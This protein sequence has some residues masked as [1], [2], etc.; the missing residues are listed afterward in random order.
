MV[1][2]LNVQQ[3]FIDS[4]AIVMGVLN[5]TPDSFYDGG[6]YT[7]EKQWMQRAETILEEG[8]QI[9]DLGAVSTR[10]GARVPEISDEKQRLIPALKQIRKEFPTAIL[11]VDTFRSEIAKM[12]VDE[13]ADMINDVSAGNMDNKMLKTISQLDVTYILMHMQGVPSNMQQ[14][15][16]YQNVI[17]DII[18]FFRD[19]IKEL[20][21]MGFDDIILDPGLGFGKTISHNYR[22]IKNL[23]AFAVMG[24]PVLVGLSR[25]SMITK[26]LNL[27]SE[28]ALNGTTVMNTI[29]LMNGARILRVHD[30]KEAV[31]AAALYKLTI[32]A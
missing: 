4:E 13:G 18:D 32:N 11:S 14:R 1:Q 29:A 24:Y 2:K 19:K 8:G 27:P 10:P 26:V 25:K 20:N 9:I 17:E 12:A 23:R 3:L 31:E 28:K 22:I 30:V 16:Y 5:L 15:P 6:K 21:A 7:T